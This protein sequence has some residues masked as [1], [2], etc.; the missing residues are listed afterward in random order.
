VTKDL[1][2][3]KVWRKWL[4]RLQELGMKFNI[5]TH[6]S[7]AYK[8]NIKSSWLKYTIIPDDY[9]CDTAWSWLTKATL[10]MYKYALE[11]SKSNWY[12]IHSESCIP[13]ITP[14]KFIENFNV[15]KH[16]TFLSHSKAW[17]TPT[18]ARNDR[19]NLHLL[20]SEYHLAHAQWCII[21]HDDLT[22]IISLT[23]SD[24]QL[25]DIITSGHTADESII[26]IFLYKINNFKNV[27]NK[28]TTITDWK[29][30]PTGCNP[31]TFMNWTEADKAAVLE[32]CADKSKNEYMFMRKIGDTFP[33]E[34]IF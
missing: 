11:N 30:S 22:Q 6:C 8:A 14:E 12:S 31:Y 17:W 27:I 28:L 18:N 13:F 29:R 3:E 24:K 26:A 7:P 20:P 23:E 5:I 15:Y 9:L 34:I 16:N 21:C 2:K 32:L 1:I 10:S 33:D 19:A 4:A 25:T